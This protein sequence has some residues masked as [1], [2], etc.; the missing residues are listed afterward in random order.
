VPAPDAPYPYSFDR[1]ASVAEVRARHGELEPGSE[2]GEIVRLAGRIK[3]VR[4]HGK[5]AFADLEDSSGT[6]QLFAQ[7]AVLGEE[8]LERF[9]KVGV[10]DIVGAE[11]EV[12]V[13]RR[14]ELSI[15]TTSFVVLAPCLRPMPD[16]WHG[17][18][19]VEVRYRQRYLDLIVNPE[20]RRAVVARA[21]ANS[22]IRSFLDGR[23]FIEVE[24]PLLQPVAGGAIAR[25]FTTHHNA[26]DIDLYLRIAPELYLKRLL[27]GGFERVYELNR[28]FRNEGVSTQHNTEFTM[29]EAYEAYVD[30][31]HTMDLVESLVR[32]I[33][34]AV[35]AA[36]GAESDLGGAFR[37]IDMFEAIEEG[38]GPDLRDAWGSQDR[39]RL[40]G[41]A[42][43]AG[44]SIAPTWP[45]GKVLMEIFEAVAE[46]RL[47]EPTFVVGMPK[48]VSPLAKDHREIPGFTEHA[49][50][51]V[52]GM[53]IAPIY[54]ELND[55][56][57][58]RRRFEAQARARAAGDAEA[59][60]PDDDFLEALAYA[61]PPAGGFGLGVDR[62]LTFLLGS[63]SLREV[64]LFPVLKPER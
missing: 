61:M 53:E 14:G 58:Q 23:G 1:T 50:L 47:H 6:I 26:L 27:I 44:V 37:R 19:D 32:E 21:A 60:L 39:A 34:R 54:S 35:G 17:V 41:A 11:G 36:A 18:T 30:F 5:V 10:G 33:A 20:S 43:D 2:T 42:T 63:G 46:K 64:I 48:D 4:S 57:E 9:G 38:G 12:I 24:T 55:P 62:L 3:T 56:E 51:I 13:T 31:H 8:G 25:P 7:H 29:L 45:A 52:G 49:D 59:H 40:E 28:S 15:R 22:S 16:T